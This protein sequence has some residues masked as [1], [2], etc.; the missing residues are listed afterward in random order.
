MLSETIPPLFY[1]DFEF[2]LIF[3]REGGSSKG[4]LSMTVVLLILNEPILFGEMSI[5]KQSSPSIP[6]LKIMIVPSSYS[7]N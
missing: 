5:C 4:I 6:Y 2:D 3:S 7:I 1:P